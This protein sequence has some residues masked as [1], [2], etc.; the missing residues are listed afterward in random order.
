MVGCRGFI[1]SGAQRLEG[2]VEHGPRA[3]WAGVGESHVREGLHTAGVIL[4]HG[5]V[6]GH[7]GLG[8]RLV[9]L[10]VRRVH[11]LVVRLR[12]VVR[13][14]H[15]M[16]DGLGRRAILR[17]LVRRRFLQSG[18]NVIYELLFSA[19]SMADKVYIGIEESCCQVKASF[20][21]RFW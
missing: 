18:G 20:N 8:L 6:R 9:L 15:G 19:D 1:T 13:W 16:V 12:F 2:A 5:Q 7:L 17:D 21:I 4:R 3:L 10:L 11:R 14:V